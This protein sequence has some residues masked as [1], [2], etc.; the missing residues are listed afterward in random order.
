MPTAEKFAGFVMADSESHRI[1]AEPSR[2]DSG[3]GRREGVSNTSRN[4][5]S[6]RY[7]ARREPAADRCRRGSYS[8][9]WR[10]IVLRQNIRKNVLPIKVTPEPAPGK[11]WLRRRSTPVTIGSQALVD[12]IGYFL[13]TLVWSNG[14]GGTIRAYEHAEC[15]LTHH[16]SHAGRLAP[17][18]DRYRSAR[19]LA[20]FLDGHHVPPPNWATLQSL[21]AGYRSLLST[22][23]W[24]SIQSQPRRATTNELA[25]GRSACSTS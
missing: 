5:P 23:A 4:P 25:N 17:N 6:H 9:W 18:P 22:P 13:S 19:V 7:F 2:V 3:R 8:V 20:C 16:L 12:H 11:Y 24:H 15:V 14:M 10:S 1:E 21:R